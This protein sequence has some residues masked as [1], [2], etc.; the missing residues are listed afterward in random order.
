MRRTILMVDSKSCT[1]EILSNLGLKAQ[2][3]KTK[4]EKS[5]RFS[6]ALEIHLNVT[7]QRSYR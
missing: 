4:S 3:L 5:I 2:E 7:G 6:P 1:H